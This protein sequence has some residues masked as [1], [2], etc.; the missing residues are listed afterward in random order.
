MK[1]HSIDIYIVVPAYK[2]AN[3]LT[4]TIEKI[5]KD[6]YDLIKEIVIV[7]DIDSMDQRSSSDDLLDR[8]KKCKVIF[9]KKNKGYGAAQKTGYTY[10]MKNGCAGVILLHADGQTAP[11]YL[12]TF[13]N[14]LVEEKADVVQGS[15]ML[16]PKQALK[17]GMPLWKY[18]L[19][20]VVT[21]FENIIFN[22]NYS[23][24]HSGYKGYSN[25][26]LR[27]I[28]F[29]N[30]SD[31]YHF[32]GEMLIMT[33][34][35]GLNFKEFPVDSYYG[36]ETSSLNTFNYALHI[37]RGIIRYILNHYNFEVDV[38]RFGKN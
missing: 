5:P 35:K 34:I 13:I 9:H 31:R 20:K 37:S 24:Y 29:E 21:K 10:C 28:G 38:D 15:R 12:E 3:T 11:K 23:E 33:K 16:I 18:C 22:T 6:V 26:A 8:F 36:E 14:I 4:K 1:D 25:K 17:G 32:D 2:A 30:L 7:E 27:Y 19:N